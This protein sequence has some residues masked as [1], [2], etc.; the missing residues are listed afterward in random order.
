MVGDT[1]EEEEERVRL[2]PEQ[3]M[4]CWQRQEAEAATLLRK[5]LSGYS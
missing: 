1:E 5:L 3:M 2:N 4:K